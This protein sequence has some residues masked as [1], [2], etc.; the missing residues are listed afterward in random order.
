MPGTELGYG[1]VFGTELEYGARIHYE[2]P[3]TELGYG[4]TPALLFCIV[5]AACA[6]PSAAIAQGIYVIVRPLP[7]HSIIRRPPTFP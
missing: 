4:A 6:V 3:G 2:M 5:Y 1:S 7:L